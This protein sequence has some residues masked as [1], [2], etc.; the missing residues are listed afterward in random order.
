MLQ[1]IIWSFVAAM[2]TA[3]GSYAVY[4]MRSPS[5]R[6]LDASVGFAAG[7]MLSATVFGLIPAAQ[8]QIDDW[9]VAL[10][11][12]AG[13][14]GI[15]LLDRLVPHTHAR[16]EDASGY[17]PKHTP[18]ARKA[19]LLALAL[20]LHNI[21]EGMAVGTAFAAGGA[22]LGVP[23]ALAIAAHNIPEG[24]AVSGPA[25][26][27]GVPRRRTAFLGALTG[28]V[29]IPAMIGAYLLAQQVESTIA[30]MLAIAAGAMLYVVFDELLPDTAQHGN[31]KIVAIWVLIGIL[32]LF[33]LQSVAADLTA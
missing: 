31:E 27:A 3:L 21:P 19:R 32:A 1:V 15:G 16:H 6:M 23:L 12:V 2:G 9:G 30:P 7:V 13:F 22:H 26:A 14:F 24:F 10:W 18:S 17:H 28:I 29:E 25:V 20:T 4:F 8:A 33:L 5:Q 11:V